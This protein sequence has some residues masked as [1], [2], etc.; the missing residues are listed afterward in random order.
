MF[1]KLYVLIT[2]IVLYQQIC[3]P[4]LFESDLISGKN[5]LSI[6]YF[7]REKVL[8]FQTQDK[9]KVLVDINGKEFQ[10]LSSTLKEFSS[11]IFSNSVGISLTTK[12][13]EKI[14][15]NLEI[16][17]ITSQSGSFEEKNK[18]F[19]SNEYGWSTAISGYYTLFPETVVNPSISL[20]LGVDIEN[21]K[22]NLFQ[23]EDRNFHI[24]TVFNTLDIFL[25]LGFYKKIISN[26]NFYFVW[27]MDYR[28]SSMLDKTNFY[29]FSGDKFLLNF[30]LGTTICLTK[31]EKINFTLMRSLD[32]SDFIGNINYSL[33]Y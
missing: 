10:Y 23:A 20:G 32:T 12:P 7:Y 1:K 19:I 25:K 11:K 6:Y 31:K 2:L 9:E 28:K 33:E 15:Y 3:F 13:F 30:Y 8:T 17:L 21:Y 29:G 14:Y 27:E 5:R 22:F 16:S 24:D 18:D 4:S 26:L